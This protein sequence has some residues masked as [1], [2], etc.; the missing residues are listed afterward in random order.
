MK[1]RLIALCLA[2]VMLL[3]L[4]PSVL[5]ANAVECF[6]RQKPATKG[7][8]DDGYVYCCADTF[9][10]TYVKGSTAMLSF[11]RRIATPNSGDTFIIEIYRGTASQLANSNNLPLVESRSYSVSK[12]ASPNY[13]L[14][15]SFNLDG[16][17]S[18]GNYAVLWGIRSPSGR[19]YS[20]DTDYIVDMKVVNS[21]IPA[22]DIQLYIQEGSNGGII[23]VGETLILRP[24][25]APLDSTISRVFT[26][27]NSQPN[28]A[29]VSM[30]AGYIYVVGKA[31]GITEIEVT[32][33]NL[34]KKLTLG[35]GSLSDFSL[36]PGKTALCVGTTDTIRTSASGAVGSPIYYTWSSSD[37]SV[38]TVNNGVVTAIKPGTVTISANCYAKT[39]S[40]TYKVNYHQLS[41][42]VLME[43]TATCPRQQVGYCTVCGKDGCANVFEPAIFTDTVYNAWYSE[44]VDFVYDIGLMNGVS[45]DKFAPN[46][47]VTRGMVVTVLYRLCGEPEV[48]G[49][50]GFSDVPAGKYYSKA[51][52]W[53]QKLGVVNG[54]NDGT[55]RPG[56][57][58]TREQLAAILYR[59][60]QA[61]DEDVSASA[62]LSG[63]P[64]AGKVHNY[65]KK[66][67]SWAVAE[68]IISGVKSNNRDYLQPDKSA[69]RAQ[70]ATIIS[71]FLQREI[72]YV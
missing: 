44:H 43:R 54:F 28:V 39:R 12:F 13:I 38:A 48:S 6:D 22:T 70:F 26:V 25:P 14:T 4:C 49:S 60:S 18:A 30:N 37:P 41:G 5:G 2:V 57:N 7:A 1:H 8:M 67:M 45:D 69:T 16:K 65:A 34:K 10:S 59:F 52:I 19:Q 3:S 32:C 20:G 66:A 21:A 23:S 55:Y 9:N 58:V 40:V 51:V 11:K 64:D 17:Y 42:A 27:K 31:V 62:N 24:M 50:S 36:L 71:R 53:A 29:A 72:P 61:F 68:G 35:V 56:D 15:A 33:G 46:N 63:Y 47:P